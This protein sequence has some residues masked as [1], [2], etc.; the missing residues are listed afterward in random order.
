M[1]SPSSS[2]AAAPIRKKSILAP[3]IRL[4]ESL[5]TINQDDH[6]NTPRP[7]KSMLLFISGM[8]SFT[9]DGGK[10]AE[11]KLTKANDEAVKSADTEEMA[12]TALGLGY[13]YSFESE[14]LERSLE[15]YQHSLSLW[16][17]LHSAQSIKLIG[18]LGDISVIQL[19][20]NQKQPALNTLLE[21]QNIYKHANQDKSTN[22]EYQSLQDAIKKLQQ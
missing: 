21:C 17:K 2:T 8:Q 1:S 10:T 5:S 12:V 14:K 9:K 22:Q 4:L 6:G 15:H 13:C 16:K 19:Q 7:S 18:L 3:P 20:L 11:E